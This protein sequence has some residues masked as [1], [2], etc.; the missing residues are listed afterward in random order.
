MICQREGLYRTRAI[1][2]SMAKKSARPL[3]AARIPSLYK[4]PPGLKGKGWVKEP[5]RHGLAA[6]GV[7][8]AVR[9]RAYTDPQVQALMRKAARADALKQLKVLLQ[10]ER[11]LEG[12][13]YLEFP[14]VDEQVE[15]ELEQV[16]DKI[17]KLE[18]ELILL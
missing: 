8:T 12:A 10:E 2:S 3:M 1:Y 15:E 13:Q 7:K 14:G 11:T 16:R 17:V 4:F 18:K 5:V 6:K 9:P